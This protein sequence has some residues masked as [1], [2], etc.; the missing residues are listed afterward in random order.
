VQAREIMTGDVATVRPDRTVREA[1]RLMAD[2]NVG[3][4]PVCDGRRLVG[5]VTDRDIT[6]RATAD[7]MLPDTTLVRAVMSEDVCWCFDDDPVEEI[8]RVMADSK[9][10][11]MPVVDRAK[12]LVGMIALG[13]LAARRGPQ[14]QDALRAISEPSRP[15]RPG[16]TTPYD[17]APWPPYGSSQLTR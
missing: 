13:D 9:I 14:T 6:V 1:A 8:E 10:R 11:R 4:L 2:L 12:R 17:D 15:R 7:G 3:A 16:P 5:I